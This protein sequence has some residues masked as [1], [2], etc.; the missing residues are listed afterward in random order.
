LAGGQDAADHFM[1][2]VRDHLASVASI[3]EPKS[4]P[5]MVKAFANL[6][7]LAQACVRDKKVKFVGDVNQF[8]IGFIRRYALVDFVD[9]G[10]GKEEAD[11]KIRG[12]LICTMHSKILFTNN[13]SEVL[14]F[15]IGNLQC[16]HIMLACCHDSGYV[17]VLRQYAAQSSYSERITLLSAGLVRSDIRALGFRSTTAFEPLFCSPRALQPTADV[18][19]RQPSLDNIQ[20]TLDLITS[21]AS[22]QAKEK[23]VNNS[24]RLRPILRNSAGKRID[25][26]LSVDVSLVQEIR[27]HNLCSWHYLRADC[28][29]TSC[30]RNHI[31][32]RPLSPGEYDAQWTVAR[33]GL[34][35]S[36]RKGGDCDD[37][38]CMYS[39]GF[40]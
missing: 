20:H 11:N 38:Q 13:C 19:D 40:T 27:K 17:P 10:P 25:K 15:H 28:Q 16:E 30:K 6:G 21:E 7:G 22:S 18:K 24:G 12:K 33:Q 8:W 35:Y 36:L 39:H 4:V 37:D 2:K 29:V 26:I 1:E 31:Y 23:P 3:K 5:V 32:P 9:V 34:C 14:G